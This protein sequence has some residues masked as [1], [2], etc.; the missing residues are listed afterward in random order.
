MRPV[1]GKAAE[2][3]GPQGARAVD[4]RYTAA[5]SVSTMS[6]RSD[7]YNAPCTLPHS[8]SLTPSH[9]PPRRGAEDLRERGERPRAFHEATSERANGPRARARGFLLVRWNLFEDFSEKF[10]NCAVVTAKEISN[11]E[12]GKCD[13][14]GAL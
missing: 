13:Q 3:G 11:D 7:F 14:F 1:E 8:R 9:P 4:S 6:A 10:V 12:V 2:R 5:T